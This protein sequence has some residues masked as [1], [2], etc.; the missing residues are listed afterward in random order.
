V[1]R[2]FKTKLFK[3]FI[4]LLFSLTLVS[5]SD[6]ET[7]AETTTE[8]TTETITEPPTTNPYEE[9]LQEFIDNNDMSHANFKSFNDN[10]ALVYITMIIILEQQVKDY[11]ELPMDER[12]EE[13]YNLILFSLNYYENKIK[14][15]NK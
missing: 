2:L 5:C 6:A 3:I 9:R 8:T 13:L 10:D 11:N 7:T 1:T 12:D 15:V 4:T 14:E